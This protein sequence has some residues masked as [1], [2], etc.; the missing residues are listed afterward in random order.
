MTDL[1]FT[2][3]QINPQR[4]AT[5]RLL[6]SPQRM[7]AAVLST[8]P[9]DTQTGTGGPRVL[10]R[11]DNPSKHEHN[12]FITGP[13]RPSLESLQQECGWSQQQT[14]KT[15]P[16]TP[17]LDKL[18]EGQRWVFRLTANP[19]RSTAGTRGTRGSRSAHVTPTQQ[20]AW[21]VHRQL[22]H[23]FELET[24]DDEPQV[25]VSSTERPTFT[26]GTDQ[27]K[28]RVTVTRVQYD[29]MLTVTNPDVLRTSLTHG[30]GP[31]KGYGCGLMTL[32]R[33]Q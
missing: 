8:Y 32:A 24:N 13:G 1:Y 6:A 4:R 31:A 28:T 12:L 23:G 15:A 21:L 3:F 9:P 33:A 20:L 29:G 10:W 5:L 18:H 17:F 30:I 26:K 2:R 16:Y 27:S 25:R 22:K 11:L 7:H 14:W 19:T